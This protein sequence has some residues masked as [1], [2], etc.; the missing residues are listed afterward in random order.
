M[1]SSCSLSSLYYATTFTMWRKFISCLIVA[2]L[3]RFLVILFVIFEVR[4][5]QCFS[6]LYTTSPCNLL[7]YASCCVPC[8]VSWCLTWLVLLQI[9]FDRLA[10]VNIILIQIN[11]INVFRY[12]FSIRLN[13]NKSFTFCTPPS[14]VIKLDIINIKFK[15]EIKNLNLHS[16]KP[17]IRNGQNIIAQHFIAIFIYIY[18]QLSTLKKLIVLAKI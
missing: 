10:M 17:L 15:D 18:L 12:M 1:F 13:I 7:C 5:H 9:K 2:C 8:D 4:S 6:T 3:L 14:W 11:S 16:G